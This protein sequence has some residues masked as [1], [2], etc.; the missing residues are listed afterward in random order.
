[1]KHTIIIVLFFL[2][3][4]VVSQAQTPA[5]KQR[6]P[7]SKQKETEAVQSRNVPAEQ[8]NPADKQRVQPHVPEKTTTPQKPDSKGTR[9]RV[10]E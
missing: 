10:D 2:T 3:S 7:E 5:E 4:V 6:I 9:K 8:K 1:M